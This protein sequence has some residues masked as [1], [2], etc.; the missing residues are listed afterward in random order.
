MLLHELF[1]NQDFE[2]NIN[3]N[4]ILYLYIQSSRQIM[5]NILMFYYV[6]IPGYKMFLISRLIF[7]VY[8]NY[9]QCRQCFSFYIH[10]HL[11]L[12]VHMLFSCEYYLGPWT[13]LGMWSTIVLFFFF[14][15]FKIA[16]SAGNIRS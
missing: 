10:I 7:R 14:D 3:F 11:H 15:I 5:N 16:L 6:H 8:C 4:A 2:M 13:C 12:C 1:L 9:L